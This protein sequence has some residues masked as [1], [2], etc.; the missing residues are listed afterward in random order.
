MNFYEDLKNCTDPLH[1]YLCSKCIPDNIDK[2]HEGEN[3]FSSLF[4]YCSINDF[5]GIL[6][7][8]FNLLFYISPI[9]ELQYI[10]KFPIEIHNFPKF[11]LLSNL[12][13]ASVQVGILIHAFQNLPYI[14]I[15]NCIGIFINLI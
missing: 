4:H 11:F 1:N 9:F 12:I 6:A 10:K 2:C 15:T 13:N 7:L 5:F 8:L 14:F 3:P